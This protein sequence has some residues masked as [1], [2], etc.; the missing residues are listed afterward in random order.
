MN[1][2]FVAGTDTSAGKT[3]V[4]GLLGCYLLKKGYRVVTQKWVQ[5]GCSGFSGDIDIHLKLMGK[6]ADDF[7]DYFS[8][9]RPYV[10]RFASSPHLAARLE[11]KRINI[12]KIEKSL[13][14]LT[15]HFDFVIVEGSGGLMV[16]LNAKNLVI[17]VIKALNIDVLVVAGNKLGV[18]N[19]TLLSIEA[20]R[21]RKIN[22]LGI[23]FNNISDDEN[24]IILKDNP[25]ILKKLTKE[26]VLG[27]L[28]WV[29]N[30]C[31]LQRRFI[32]IGN[33]ISARY[34]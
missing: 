3:V 28:P 30:P 6:K 12:N 10:F 25:E 18:I 22:I 7:L 11:G 2:I 27:I 32:P 14:S 26:E 16:P 4:T 9:M 19:H 1:T 8:L 21:A 5:T 17:D 13:N 34:E 24:K 33:K 31:R 15:K 23:I 20:L 29:K